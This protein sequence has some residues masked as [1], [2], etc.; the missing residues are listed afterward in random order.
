MRGGR[1]VQ[2]GPPAISI[3]ARSTSPQ[4]DS[5]AIST[6]STGSSREGR[7]QTP[8]GS[9]DAPGL[10]DGA[11]AVVCIRPQALRL[12]GAGLLPAGARHGAA[13]PWRDR[14]R[15][16]RDAGPRRADPARLRGSPQAIQG[17]DVGVDIDP[18]EVLV[19][20]APEA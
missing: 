17:A 1:I 15:R 9:F 20:A 4:R 3:I 18:D 19:F 2:A 10:P 6:R 14:P 7:A 13:L 16:D 11:R 12:R 5:S 8:L